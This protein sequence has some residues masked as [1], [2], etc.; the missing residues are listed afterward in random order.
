VIRL[1][2]RVSLRRC[3]PTR[4][5][6]GS[7]QDVDLGCVRR[8]TLLE[9]SHS[10]SELRWIRTVQGSRRMVVATAV[11]AEGARLRAARAIDP[12]RKQLGAAA[13]HGGELSVGGC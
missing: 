10:E 6:L 13:M 4:S 11:A 8:E 1:L 2:L 12:R 9:Q 7:H 5:R 3:A